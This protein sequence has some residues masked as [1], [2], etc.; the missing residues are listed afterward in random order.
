VRALL[1]EENA[2]NVLDDEE[3]DMLTE[4]WKKSE[5]NAKGI[6][7]EH[8]SDQRLI[9]KS[10]GSVMKRLEIGDSVILIKYL[11]AKPVFS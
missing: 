8:L 6:I 2:L 1:A 7:I 9:F 3:P 5:R 4:V 11:Q 10:F